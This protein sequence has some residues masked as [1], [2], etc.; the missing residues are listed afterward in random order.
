[1]SIFGVS[2]VLL[3]ASLPLLRRI[4]ERVD[5]VVDVKLT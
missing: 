4:D 1:V 2:A 3:I 5:A